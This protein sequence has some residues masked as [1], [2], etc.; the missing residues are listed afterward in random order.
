MKK[1]LQL[2]IVL[3]MGYH[4]QAQKQKIQT[5]SITLQ[6]ILTEVTLIKKK[7]SPDSTPVRQINGDSLY[8]VVSIGVVGKSDP[9]NTA[10]FGDNIWVKLNDF[11]KFI[12]FQNTF[13]KKGVPDSLSE[14]ILYINGNPMRDIGVSSINANEKSLV[15]HLDRH[16]PYLTKFYAYFPYLWSNFHAYVSVGFR[17][18]VFIG[19]EGKANQFYLRYIDNWAWLS[20]F[21]LI[22]AILVSALLLGKKTNLIRIGDEKSPYS[23]SLTQLAF[24]T[25]IIASSFLYIWVITGE[26]TP[27]TGS[28]LVLLSI[29]MATTGGSRLVDIQRDPKSPKEIPPTDGFIK[30]LLSDSL[31]Y[32]VHRCQMFLWT[33]ILGFIFISDVIVKQKMPQLDT[34]LLGLM[35]ISSGA[36]VG[37]KMVEN[38][39]AV[40]KNPTKEKKTEP[41]K[42]E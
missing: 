19:T 36:Y 18:G 9:V 1:Y 23:L 41:D 12:S 25:L 42:A 27:L 22:A 30:D 8:K 39:P 5:D 38:K 2:F 7:L 31:G 35:G 40:K 13:H 11:D 14:I 16:S 10:D 32:S 28:T 6:K 4:L 17:N 26:L 24:W 37:L 20:T 15:F 29:S 3:I 33:I 34:T 21:F